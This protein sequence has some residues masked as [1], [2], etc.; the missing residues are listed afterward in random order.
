MIR[1]LLVDDSPTI[2][3]S[4][5]HALEA[6]PDCAVVGSLGSG[7]EALTE[8]PRVNPDIILMDVI[9]PGISGIDVTRLL[10]DVHP[11][12]VIIMSAHGERSLLHQAM[13]AGASEYLIKPF[14]PAEVLAAIRRVHALNQRRVSYLNDAPTSTTADVPEVFAIF[15]AK[16]GSGR[17]LLAVNLAAAIAG[18][19]EAR[20]ALV[21]LD[22]LFGDLGALLNL[23]A[24]RTIAGL[25]GSTNV[26]E[27]IGQAM[28]EGPAKV[29]V[30]LAPPRP[31]LAE[32]IDAATMAQVF[33]TLKRTFS[34]V[35]VDL[36]TSFSEIN[37][38]AIDN[39]TRV[40]LVT[41]P[42]ISATIGAR[43]ALRTFGA[44]ELPADQIELVINHLEDHPAVSR[45]HIETALG[46]GAAV[47]IPYDRK[48]VESATAAAQPFVSQSPELEISRRIRDLVGR[49][50]PEQRRT[51]TPGQPEP[52]A[53]RRH[54]L[55]ARR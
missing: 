51:A 50:V 4:L 6:E 17:S 22:F 37:L 31:E 30:L 45:A 23:D 11:A 8:V 7:E 27:S 34:F 26:E 53:G 40:V 35:V 36:P 3:A 41:T 38:L 18:M 14:E 12:P 21:D 49:L 15:S 20:V 46:R 42:T 24:A 9:M 25:A 13:Q 2:R 1:V 39:A 52:A 10:A 48:A 55:F 16:G 32:T 47:E 19:T 5:A 54:R 29:S 33:A 28:Q 43:S 44:L